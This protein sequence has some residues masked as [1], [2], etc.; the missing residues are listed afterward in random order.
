MK[1]LEPQRLKQT[2]TSLPLLYNYVLSLPNYQLFHIDSG[3]GL[4]P[5]TLFCGFINYLII[6]ITIKY[7]ILEDVVA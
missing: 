1:Y 5:D 6:Y 2:K 3:P 7:K 4:S